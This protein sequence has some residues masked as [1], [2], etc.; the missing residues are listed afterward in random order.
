MAETNGVREGKSIGPG[1]GTSPKTVTFIFLL[2]NLPAAELYIWG[3]GALTFDNF[4][5]SPSIYIPMIAFF[6]LLSI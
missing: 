3:I 6:V 4:I 2:F 1:F 5:T